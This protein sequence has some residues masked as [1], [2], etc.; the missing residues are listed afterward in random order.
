MKDI[1]AKLGAGALALVLGACGGGTD[2]TGAVPP[3]TALTSSGAMQKG[4]V[5]LNGTH[6]DATGATVTDDRGR[7]A[8]L[9][10]DGMVIKLRGRSDDGATGVADRIEIGNEARGTVQ[11]IDATSNPPRFVVAGLVVLVDDQTVYANLS[12]FAAITVATRVEV[13]GLRDSLGLVHAT[14]V[15]AVGAQDGL[16]EIRGLVTSIL[17]G[18][19][20][21]TLNGSITVDYGAATFAPA[22]ASAAMLASGVLVEVR[23]TLN[24]SVFAAA[25]V[26]I[27]DLEDVPFDGN[28]NEHRDVEGFISGFSAHP[29][30][31]T[32]NGQ[33]VRTTAATLFEGGAAADLS[34]DVKVEVDGVLDAQRVLVATKVKFRRTRVILQ[35]LVSAVQ[36]SA[37]TLVQMGQ[38]VRANDLTR[39]DARPAGGGG[40]SDLLADVTAGVDC[41]ESRGHI[42]GAAF[43]AER[44]RELNQ[45][46][47]DVIQASVS[48]KDAGTGV[49]SFFGGGLVAALAATAELRDANDLV[50]P[51]TLFFTLINAADATRQGTLVKLRGTFAD[52]TFTATE[53]AIEN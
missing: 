5:I 33:A 50:V 8:A 19:H 12:G 22:G 44:I 28:P 36:L 17:P 49:L 4:S 51:R 30:D 20:Q 40:H 7:T 46:N 27:E 6:F 45:C 29:G 38:V 11:S 9:L 25:V 13:H 23:G 3:T 24:G 39:I 47:A 53:A 34:N 43:I 48:A 15:E 42:E 26:D 32:V 41:V 52:G 14:R 18:A 37:R 35:S 2:G 10:D 31:F 21:L 16:D 1:L